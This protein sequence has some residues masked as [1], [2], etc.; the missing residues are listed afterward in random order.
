[1]YNN[2]YT[3]ESVMSMENEQL[4]TI[5]REFMFSSV[6]AKVYICLVE[7]GRANGSQIAK[8]LGLSRSSV[9]DALES[10]AKKGA[11]LGV[12]GVALDFVAQEPDELLELLR[13]SYEKNFDFLQRGLENIP[14]KH[15]P[16][17]IYN[18]EGE[19]LV[20]QKTRELIQSTEHEIY[21][22]SCLDLGPFFSD[23]KAASEKGVRI[24]QFGFSAERLE[25]IELEF[26]AFSDKIPSTQSQRRHM[27]IADMKVVILAE[28]KP[29]FG[30]YS[31]NN[32]MV[33][34][35]AEHF[36][37]DVYLFK[38]AQKNG[39]EIITPEIQLGTLLEKR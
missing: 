18:V 34:L 5:L 2:I 8:R 15:E 24:I 36:H 35:A 39:R 38:L 6:E 10:L 11:A 9:Y 25:G 22:N 14:R 21:I 28:G 20:F 27:M 29:L 4:V 7:H 26:Y 3:M 17:M 19:V 37:L 30:M 12:P 33:K 1:M 13:R 23:L 16:E 31:K 32:L